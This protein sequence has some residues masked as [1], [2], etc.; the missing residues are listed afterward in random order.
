MLG[1]QGCTNYPTGCVPPGLLIDFSHTRINPHSFAIVS[2]N[3]QV[4]PQTVQEYNLTFGREL[5]WNTGLQISYIG[6]H[7][8]N[9]MQDEPFNYLVPRDNC[10]A[11]N[12]L[13]VAECQAGTS[14]YRRPFGDFSTSSATNYNQ[15]NY[16]GYGNTNELQVQ[17]THTV[18]S[19]LLFQV[20]F[21]WLKALNT[22]GGANQ[23]GIGKLS[24]PQSSAIPAAITPGYSLTDPLN[25]GTPI[26]QRIA[27]VYSND[28]NLP[29]KE[30]KFNANYVFPFGR[31]QRFLSNAHGLLNA[32]VSGYTLSPY[33]TWHSGFYFAPYSTPLASRTYLAPGKTGILP[34]SERT[35]DHWFDASIANLGAGQPYTGQTYIIKATPEEGD[36]HNNI[37]FNYMTGPGFN[38]MDLGLSKHTPIWKSVNLD[39]AAQFFN[40]YNH[41]NWG[42]PNTKGVING[43]VGRARTIQL[44]AKVVF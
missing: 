28:P 36:Y 24:I 26:S 23:L 9:Q 7:Y 35:P 44:Q 27:A 33:F 15:L 41:I 1:S 6:N 2:V 8:Y 40:V 39:F 21:T 29:A 13:D 25:T 17:L 37:P 34:E 31:G 20:Y 14:R 43:G 12:S 11:A 4:K 30:F 19:N 16:N 3:P 22:I 38:E 10:A 18:T 42:L 32:L 5:P